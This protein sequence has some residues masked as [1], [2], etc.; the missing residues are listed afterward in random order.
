MQFIFNEVF[1][2]HETGSHPENPKRLKA[3]KD[4]PNATLIDGT[5]FLEL[6]HS[7]LYVEKV[8]RMASTKEWIDA[9]TR[10][11]PGSFAA[12]AG[13]TAA[14]IMASES[15]DFALVRPPGH[16]AYA[17]HGSGFCLFNNVAIATQKLV[18]E[19]KRVLIFDFD[20][21]YGDGTADTFYQSDQVLYWS[22]HQYPAFPG[23]GF[24]DEIG[25]GPGKGFTINV[26]LPPDSGD[27]IFLHAVQATLPLA[28][29]FK[30]DVVAVSAGFD[31]H[32][33][34]P[35]LDLRLSADSYYTLGQI[36]QQHFHHYFATLEGGYNIQELPKCIYNFVAG[37]NGEAMPH[38]ERSTTSAR[39]IWEEYELRLHTLF[40]YLAPFWKL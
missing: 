18:A 20:G 39:R 35:L 33:S 11:S 4:L 25:E 34:D 10:V 17:D 24:M 14:T 29:Q 19:G 21:H 1:L 27:D 28:E 7:P 15:G 37:I 16:H 6:V 13:A 12:A 36:V 3:F 26:P 9:D 22:L 40:N 8:E 31:A 38:S 23:K 30:P 32:V 5:P 2:T